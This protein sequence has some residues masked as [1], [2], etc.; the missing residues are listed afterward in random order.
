MT[1][2][3]LV[4]LLL[5]P[6]LLPFGLSSALAIGSTLEVTEVTEPGS[7]F[8]PPAGTVTRYVTSLGPTLTFYESRDASGLLTGQILQAPDLGGMLPVV[9]PPLLPIF[10][11]ADGVTPFASPLFHPRLVVTETGHGM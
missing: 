2:T 3:L 11:E 1:R 9:A 5:A 7:V 6:F 8:V 4:P 10:F